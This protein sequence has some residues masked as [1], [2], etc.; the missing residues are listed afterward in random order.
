MKAV[1][2]VE[3]DEI[4]EHQ[5]L[6]DDEEISIQK[7]KKALTAQQQ[8]ILNQK[9][10]LKKYCNERGGFIQMLCIRNNLLFNELDIE[11]QNISRIIYLATFIDYNTNQE[12]LLIKHGQ[13]YKIEPMNKID[14]QNKLK[15]KVDPFH[16]FMQDVKKNG[17]LFEVDG[18]FYLSNKYF[19]KGKSN[20]K[21][22]E[23]TRI[24]IKPVQYLYEHTTPRQ[25]GALSYVYQLI[26]YMNYETNI[27]CSNPLET[28]FCKLN[29]MSLKEVC[30]M[31]GLKTDRKAT[32]RLK[33]TL[34]KFYIKVDN[35]RY[36]VFAYAVINGNIDYYVVNPLVVW[37]GN[38][39]DN[40]KEVIKLCF[41]K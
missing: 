21:S 40:L 22:K 26:P 13:N 32:Y 35:Q 27:I 9:N 8:K 15:L 12:N 1:L 6:Q 2:V 28:D 7:K 25:H 19:T 36:Y 16:S 3:D 20:F 23:Y 4:I 11:K 34:S 38:N 37:G 29:K 10:E 31:L 18:K 17:L 33:E 24:F 5:G 39:A 30:F 14:I 41:F